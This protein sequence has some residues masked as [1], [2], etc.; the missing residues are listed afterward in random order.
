[1]A[2]IFAL[3]TDVLSKYSLYAMLYSLIVY[4]IKHVFAGCCV[5]SILELCLYV[6]GTLLFMICI[7]F[8][9]GGLT[10]FPL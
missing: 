9:S 1:M 7:Y 2:I 4:E 10:S 6:Y 3:S 8:C 5:V